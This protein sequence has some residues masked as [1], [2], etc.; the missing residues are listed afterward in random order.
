MGLERRSETD[1]SCP[2]EAPNGLSH[3]KAKGALP[4]AKI[5]PL[6]ILFVFWDT[7]SDA[8]RVTPDSVL[9]ARGHMGC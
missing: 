3:A 1:L 2:G 5:Y 8:Q 4:W 6:L 9:R 7:P